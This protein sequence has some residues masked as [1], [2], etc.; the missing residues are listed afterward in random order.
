MFR[1]NGSGGVNAENS[2]GF[3]LRRSLLSATS[4]ATTLLFLVPGIADAQSTTRDWSGPFVGATVGG[5]F[6]GGSID[7]SYSDSSNSPPTI[8]VPML[9][10]SGSI[11]GGYNFQR[12]NF[13]YGLAADGSALVATGQASGSNY[14]ANERLYGLLSLRGRLGLAT[15]PLLLYATGG[16]AGGYARFDTTISDGA[17]HNSTL[18]A[19]MGAGF[20]FGPT[21]G[22]GGEYAINDHVSL[23]AEGTVTQLGPLTASGDN[24]KGSYTASSRTT[25]VG[26]RGGVNFHF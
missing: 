1:T 26:V 22:A 11:V 18:A 10:P 7:L 12:G 19:A 15:G 8:G 14:S 4:L 17:T 23:T 21:V 24:G 9:G 3:N 2:L 25:T 5:T 16:I 6:G 13:V 20:V